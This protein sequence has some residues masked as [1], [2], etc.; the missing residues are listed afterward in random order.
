MPLTVIRVGII[1]I[2]TV[3]I[4]SL[5]NLQSINNIPNLYANKSKYI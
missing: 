1:L 5:R 3:G 4:N 2:D